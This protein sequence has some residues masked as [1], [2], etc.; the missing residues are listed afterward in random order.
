MMQF[1][2]LQKKLF[3]E[4]TDM[5]DFDFKCKMV[6]I[7]RGTE[8]GESREGGRESDAWNRNRRE[9]GWE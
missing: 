3:A 6:Y 4:T 8:T 9:T 1:V 2:Y 5:I 7:G